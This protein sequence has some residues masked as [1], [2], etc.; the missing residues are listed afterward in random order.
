MPVPASCRMNAAVLQ[1]LSFFPS[2]CSSPGQA[3]RWEMDGMM[4]RAPMTQSQLS[5]LLSWG[6]RARREKHR[7]LAGPSA[8][9][10]PMGG[11]IR[12]RLPPPR[13]GP[14]LAQVA[15]SAA[16]GEIGVDGV[17]ERASRDCSLSTHLPPGRFLPDFAKSSSRWK[18]GEH[19][20]RAGLPPPRLMMDDGPLSLPGEELFAGMWHVGGGVHLLPGE[21]PYAL[22]P[23]GWCMDVCG[24]DCGGAWEEPSGD[25]CQ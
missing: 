21:V 8:S 10:L 19:R 25:F 22:A 2:T 3:S 23:R 1:E 6:I 24:N 5:V 12:H 4:V 14:P 20:T 18:E 15:P 11:S 16:T 17:P 9:P 7:E 13:G